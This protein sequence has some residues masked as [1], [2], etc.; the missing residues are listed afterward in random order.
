MKISGYDPWQFPEDP[1]DYR[2]L[3]GNSNGIGEIHGNKIGTKIAVIGAGCSGLCAAFELMKI[4]LHPVVYESAANPDG[5]PRIGGRAYTYRFPGDP[6]AI[7]ELGGM[8]FPL[9]S[10]TLTYY[11]DQFGIDYSQPFPDPLLVPTIL[12]IEGKQH[13][14]PVGGSL[15]PGLQKAAD[16]W[17][18]LIT[19]LV[20][21]M[22]RAWENPDL[23]NQQWQIF[24]DQYANKSFFEVLYDH[25]MSK[26]EIKLFGSLGIGTGGFDSLYQISFLEILRVVTCKWETRQRLIKGGVDQLPINLWNRSRYCE[27]WGETSVRQLNNGQPLSTVKEIYSPQDPQGK[28]TIIDSK[29]N[30]EQYDAVLLSCSLRALEMD[31]KI[32]RSSFPDEVWASIHNSHLTCAGKVFVRT[33]TAFWKNQNPISTLNCTITDEPTRGTYLFDFDNT[34]SGVIC[35]S[36]TWGDSSIKFNALSHEER[37]QTCLR[38]L[39][40]IYGQDLI[41]N[42]IAES[43]SFFWEEARGYNGAFKLNYPGQ[44]EY[45]QTLFHQPYTPSSPFHNGLFLAS[46]TTS[47]AGGWIEGA[48]HSGLNAAMA[49]IQRLG[50]TTP[51]S[52]VK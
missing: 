19:P 17:N 26:Q 44:Y 25:G 14:I 49:I 30:K 32:N 39:E 7:A 29:D 1:F 34:D 5:S 51:V 35:L 38:T 33:Q 42:H 43:I 28:I 48:L 16:A 8:R 15:P 9:T 6:D 45:Q 23:R 20:E 31:I 27:H 46:D 41:S 4:G 50:G 11:L 52:F 18:E 13:F 37:V 47:W 10:R 12:Y 24:V 2:T 3:I 22:A 40:K 36:Y 21:K